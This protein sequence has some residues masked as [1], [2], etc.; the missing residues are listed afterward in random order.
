MVFALS[1]T[2]EDRGQLSLVRKSHLKF[3]VHSIAYKHV[4]FFIVYICLIDFNTYSFSLNLLF[5]SCHF[6]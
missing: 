2:L 1:I 6:Y 5:I 4:N 3:R